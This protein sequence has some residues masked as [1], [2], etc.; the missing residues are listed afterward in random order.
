VARWDFTAFT[1][2]IARRIAERDRL[3]L[4]ERLIWFIWFALFVCLVS[5][6][7]TS[8]AGCSKRLSS[9]AAASEDARR[10]LQYVEPLS[11]ARTL[12]ADFFSILREESARSDKGVE[13]ID[14][15]RWCGQGN[16]KR[17]RIVADVFEVLRG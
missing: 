4:R 1:S 3:D 12:L 16:H 5:F 11:E 13:V 17:L 6:S 8:Q 15:A 7:Q 10:T 14:G 9:K 2:G